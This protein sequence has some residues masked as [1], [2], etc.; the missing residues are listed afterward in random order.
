[1]KLNKNTFKYTVVRTWY[2]I[3]TTINN[4]STILY[5]RPFDEF[6]L[7]T[8]CYND[9]SKFHLNDN[10]VRVGNMKNVGIVD[11]TSKVSEFGV[12]LVCIFLHLDQKY[13]EHGHFS[14]SVSNPSF[15]YS[16]VYRIT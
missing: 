1:M 9:I 5:P 4:N 13:S 12:F 2:N 10:Q 3:Y 11:I 15:V 14:C 8:C 6:L 16:F 7:T